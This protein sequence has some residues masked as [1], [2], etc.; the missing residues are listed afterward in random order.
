[1][2]FQPTKS[3]TVKLSKL[4]GRSRWTRRFTTQGKPSPS[5]YLS[6]PRCR[7][8]LT[9]TGT[10]I[11]HRELKTIVN[12]LKIL[13]FLTVLLRMFGDPLT[14]HYGGGYPIYNNGCVAGDGMMRGTI[15]PRKRGAAGIIGLGRQ[16]SQVHNTNTLAL[17][18]FYAF[19]CQLNCCLTLTCDCP[20]T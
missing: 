18:I 19:H 3:S 4:S 16:R 15:L 1:M 8:H 20:Y 5:C 14:H 12:C 17:H 10:S 7:W 9:C 6:P 13:I 2:H 11:L